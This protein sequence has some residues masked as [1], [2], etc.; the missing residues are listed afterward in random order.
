M[1]FLMPLAGLVCLDER[2]YSSVR[3]KAEMRDRGYRE[4]EREIGTGVVKW[5]REAQQQLTPESLSLSHS[6]QFFI[7]GFLSL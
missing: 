3:E 5:V 1:E 2:N 6:L 4:R 7:P